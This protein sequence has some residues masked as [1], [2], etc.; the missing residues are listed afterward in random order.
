MLHTQVHAR[1]LPST[2]HRISCAG[3]ATQVAPAQGSAQFLQAE[4]WVFEAFALIL[5]DAFG[6]LLLHKF[7]LNHTVL[8]FW[9]T[10]LSAL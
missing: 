9:S 6:V 8:P 5:H 10:V 4:V 3:T 7:P 1:S 2:L